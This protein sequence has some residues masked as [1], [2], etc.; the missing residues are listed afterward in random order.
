M[1]ALALLYFDL[2][3]ASRHS[4]PGQASHPLQSS[5]EHMMSVPKVSRGPSLKASWCIRSRE[6]PRHPRLDATS[7]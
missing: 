1:W 4:R 5:R 6:T 2:P 3:K 7:K